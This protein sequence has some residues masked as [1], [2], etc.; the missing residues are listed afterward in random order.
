[1]PVR[2]RRGL[3]RRGRG[4]RQ[5][6]QGGGSQG[7]LPRRASGRG[8]GG[9]CARPESTTSSSPAATRSRPS[10]A[11]IGASRPEAKREGPHDPNSRFH[12]HA[13]RR[14]LDLARS[15]RDARMDDARGDRRQVALR[16]RRPRRARFLARLA[17]PSALSARALSDDVCQPA[18]DGAPV[19][20]LFDRRGVERLLSRQSRRRPEGTLRRLRPRDPSRLRF[21]PS[22][23]RRRRRH[24][25]G[26]D[27]LDL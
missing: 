6:G 4:V 26:R 15:G 8:G 9:A 22:A 17:G 7:P 20:R 5:G 1:M 10:K 3:R 18:V 21:R 19:R 14:R 24:G 16:P 2:R 25:R 12:P 27:R 23:R 11:S 13:L